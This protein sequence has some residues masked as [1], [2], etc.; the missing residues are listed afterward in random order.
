MRIPIIRAGA[1]IPSRIPVTVRPEAA[2]MVEEALGAAS[3]DV[4]HLLVQI[5]NQDAEIRKR[6]QE[7]D[8]L[9]TINAKK[10]DLAFY[11][12]EIDKT[13]DEDTTSD[14]LNRLS[15][16]MALSNKKKQELLKDI[17]DNLLRKRAELEL[18]RN[19]LL[20]GLDQGKKGREKKEGQVTADAEAQILEAA[21]KGDVEGAKKITK[22]LVDLG[23]KNETWKNTQDNKV[24]ETAE[25]SNI[26]LRLGSQDAEIIN[27]LITDLDKGKYKTINPLERANYKVAAEK[28]VTVLEEKAKK[29]SDEVAEDDAYEKLKREWHNNYE[30]MYRLLADPGWI[31]ENNLNMQRKGNLE[32]RLKAE[33]SLK[34][35]G[36]TRIHDETA[37]DFFV[38]IDSLK[39]EEIKQAVGEDRIDLARADAFRNKVLNP[40]DV[41]TDPAEY[42]SILK[43]IDE[44]KERDA[45]TKRI[46]A[47][48][49]LSTEDKK[50]LGRSVYKEEDRVNDDWLK[51]ARS[52][53][54]SQIIPKRGILEKIVRTPKEELDYYNAI[55]A[56]DQRLEEA[57]KSGKPIEGRDIFDLATQIAPVY[58]KSLAERMI[59]MQRGMVK[60]GEEIKTATEKEKELKKKATKFK[61]IEEVKNSNLTWEDKADILELKFGVPRAANR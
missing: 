7:A 26:A 39:M 55:K 14:P 6:Y 18:N 10:G 50:A 40:P 2:G 33:Q 25:K 37:K 30:G 41:K 11:N 28:T 31:K 5:S 36:T 1:E 32:N 9:L 21:N 17:P 29:E 12:Q 44:R 57:K 48:T 22:K 13:L 8:S 3:Q 15:T 43:D 20:A 16:F 23:I 54:E 53:L 47:S 27:S 49:K 46:L 52:F 51:Q 4:Q 24:E 59:E 38:R 56:L 60:A 61:T 45:T 42:I 34:E 19:I 35:Q 58:Q